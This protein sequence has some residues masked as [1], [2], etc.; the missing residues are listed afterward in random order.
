MS[1]NTRPFNGSSA[2]ATFPTGVSLYDRVFGGLIALLV[3]SL[4]MFVTLLSIWWFGESPSMASRTIIIPP[5]VDPELPLPVEQVELNLVEFDGSES[6]SFTE[7]LEK[8]ED[9]LAK[10]SETKLAESEGTGIGIAGD[11]F[12]PGIGIGRMPGPG[13]GN[14]APKWNVI[15]DASDLE[16]YQRKLDFFAIEIGAVHKSS[17]Q[18]WRIAHLSTK[19]VVAESTRS[20]ESSLRYF[21]NQRTRL[22]QWDRQTIAQAGVD[23]QDVIAVHFYPDELIVKMQQLIDAKYKDQAGDLREVNFKIVG[24]PG[25]FRFEIE[26]VGFN[27]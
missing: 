27:H 7:S 24:T 5:P 13:G 11:G 6:Q 2:G 17:D 20:A 12:G 21:V 22:L 19:K 10:L 3:L 14:L 25:D 9:S 18:I 16:S 1:N 23:V 8:T 15:Q 26:D 4:F